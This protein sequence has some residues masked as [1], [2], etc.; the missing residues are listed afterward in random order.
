MLMAV[1]AWLIDVLSWLAAFVLLCE[2]LELLEPQPL[3][4]SATPASGT[5]T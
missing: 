4:T 2:L 3:A 1:E 5:I